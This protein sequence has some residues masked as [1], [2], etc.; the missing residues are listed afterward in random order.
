MNISFG[1]AIS[2]II[3]ACLSMP[4]QQTQ[5]VAGAKIPG[6]NCEAFPDNN[7]WHAD[8]SALPVH[9][10]SAKWLSNMSPGTHLSPDFGP[11][12]G[13]P[14]TVVSRTHPLVT[15]D[16]KHA[17][18]SDQQ[19]YPLGDDT[20]ME[21]NNDV[22]GGRRSVIVRDATL[23]WD[24]CELYETRGARFKDG[25]WQARNGAVWNLTSNKL[26]PDETMSADTAG[27]PVL[28]GLLRYEETTAGTIDH[29]IR[30]TSNIVDGN[31]I[32]PARNHGSGVKNPDYPPMGARFRLKAGYTIAAGLRS[33][34]KAVLT[35]M[36]RY[37]LVLA[38]VGPA[39][40]FQGTADQRW[41]QAMLDELK[42][43]PA[44]A[45]EAVETKSLRFSDDSMVV[46]LLRPDVLAEGDSI[47]IFWGGNYT[48]IFAATKPGLRMKGAAVGGARLN[49][50]DGGNGLIQRR[51]ADLSH[52]PKVLT[53]LIGANDLG[54]YVYPTG[55]AYTD[56]L[57]AYV[58]P[59]RA[60]GT[61]VAVA[62]IL[63]R[64]A[65]TTVAYDA[66]HNARRVEAN[67]LI[68]AAVG[69][70]ID[71]VIDFAADPVM[72]TDSAPLDTTLYLDG[73]H[74]TN[75]CALGCGGQGKLAVIYKAAVDAL[76]AQTGD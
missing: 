62:T 66:I 9:R 35:A 10:R 29:A 45:F 21:V 72:G 27:L 2:L 40:H 74:P 44:S 55:K 14:I 11:S 70:Q 20:L 19:T 43:V 41:P 67:K 60:A 65:P 61:K 15:V 73:V 7:W 63:A 32:W 5:A 30:F 24:H 16:F 37:G 1:A 51:S 71:A 18:Q 3:A 25:K 58:A 13:I 69:K 26:R 56:A 22:T 42:Q 59:F 17:R 8:I 57:F 50:E 23:P 53:V 34:T 52:H 28:P 64:R 76:L 48:G 75:A 12:S 68:R 31:H 39:W 36:K 49:M 33:D 38:D 4:A 6:S 54:T 47:S 46:K